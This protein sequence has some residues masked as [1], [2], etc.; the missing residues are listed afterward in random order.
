MRWG[1]IEEDM[2]IWKAGIW[3]T[4]YIEPLTTDL[5]STSLLRAQLTCNLLDIVVDGLEV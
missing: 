1:G 5:Q 3:S 4:T 2:V